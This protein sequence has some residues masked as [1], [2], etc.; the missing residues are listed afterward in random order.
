MKVD[1]TKVKFEDFY[2]QAIILIADKTEELL[3]LN[4]RSRELYGLNPT[5]YIPHLSLLYGDLTRGRKSKIA[6]R[7]GL[8]LPERVTIDRLRL[9]RAEG[10]RVEDWITVSEFP[11]Q[12]V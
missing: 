5:D 1:L 4:R 7:L 2:Y 6:R 8:Q 10:S 12:S 11:L 3:T 9:I